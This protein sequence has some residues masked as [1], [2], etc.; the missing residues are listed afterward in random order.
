MDSSVAESMGFFGLRA[1]ENVGLN[2]VTGLKE[3]CG[4]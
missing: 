3:V 1:E 4:K 2:D